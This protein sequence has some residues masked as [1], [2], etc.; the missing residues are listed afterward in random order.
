MS[1][2]KRKF[3][4]KS[5]IDKRELKIENVKVEAV[6]LKLVPFLQKGLLLAFHFPRTYP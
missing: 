1:N 6:L 5:T 2:T 4:I 3:I